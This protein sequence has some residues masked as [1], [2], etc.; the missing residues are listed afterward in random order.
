[1]INKSQI[2]NNNSVFIANFEHTLDKN[3]LFFFSLTLIMLFPTG[4]YHEIP[5][6]SPRVY[7]PSSHPTKKAHKLIIA[8]PFLDGRKRVSDKNE[9]QILRMT[10]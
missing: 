6:T 10:S 3:L 2:D 9:L 4:K 1:M 8:R 7:K 5:E